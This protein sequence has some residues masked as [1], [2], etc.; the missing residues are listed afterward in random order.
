M[1]WDT[2][3]LGEVMDVKHGFAFKSEFFSDSGD[4]V[5]LTPGNC[6]ESGGLKLKGDKE[7]YYVGDFLPEFLLNEGDML[8]VM[9]DLINAAPI[10]GRSFVIPESNRFL[11][12]QRL[13]LVQVIDD[14]RIDRTFL[15]YLLNTHEYRAQV[16]GSAT[17]STVRH[18]APDRI[19]SCSVYIP[20]DVNYQRQIG[21]TLAAYDALI[22]NNRR[23]IALLED[24]A[25]QIYREW[26]VRL[27]FP[28]HEHVVIAQ[29][30]PEGLERKT[31]G[32]LCD[33]IRESATP[34]TLDPDTRYI[35]LEHIPRRSISLCEW[36]SVEEVTSSK[37]RFQE[38]DILF[39][40]IRPYF[41]KV[42]LAFFG[43]VASSDA[44]VIRPRC[45]EWRSL[46]LMTVSSEDFVRDTAQSMR[47][48]SKMPRADWK[49]M[50]K[51]PVALPP[52][53]LL[54]SFSGA[55]TAITRQLRTLCFQNLKLVEARDLL[56]PRL[57]SG[58]IA[59]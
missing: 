29:G 57:M 38:G 17:G 28:G 43:G 40:K 50:T 26:F 23:R 36:G 32:D 33:Q 20:T 45:G 11:H 9:T 31:L 46:L 13:G 12:N 48:G 15:Y 44:I 56:L 27:R 52:A 25:A 1:K 59:A 54:D 39:G 5:L 7:K 47:E 14:R 4:Y 41:H 10:L 53:G 16:R 37:H 22:A 6:D 3:R 42:G 34:D 51:Y 55:I 2:I 24:A 18:T 30:I 8:V 19:K 58:E 21:E 35:G 49:L